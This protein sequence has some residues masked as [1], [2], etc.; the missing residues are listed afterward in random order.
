MQSSGLYS[1]S[2]I[3]KFICKLTFLFFIAFAGSNH[4]LAELKVPG[5]VGKIYSKMIA[6][7]K[8]KAKINGQNLK[9]V[10]YNVGLLKLWKF[11]I[12][13]PDFE[14]RSK[15]LGGFF[16]NYLK[17]ENP[18][19]VL[20]QELW[21]KPDFQTILAL[22]KEH[23]YLPALSDAPGIDTHSAHGLQILVKKDLVKDQKLSAQYQK[24]SSQGFREWITSIERG[25]IHLEFRGLSGKE[26]HIFNTHLSPYPTFN[27]KASMNEILQS[28]RV[29]QSIELGRAVSESMVLS[30]YVISGGDFNSGPEVGGL[31]SK[32]NKDEWY[33]DYHPYE[34]FLITANSN[35][36]EKKHLLDSYRVI[37]PNIPG[38]TQ[39]QKN[40]LAR[41]SPNSGGEPDQRLDY[42]FIGGKSAVNILKSKL[43]FNDNPKS[44]HYGIQTEISVEM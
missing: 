41:R 9:I 21:H 39:D 44:D 18:E 17:D 26:Y 27:P 35:K 30:D 31:T 14:E 10:T 6:E 16:G 29:Q 40:P 36:D 12:I 13:E 5:A 19:I 42:I 7:H 2:N 37:N 43:Q 20:L 34:Q 28:N 24:F 8:N 3:L 15:N 25:F 32:H 33:I 1:I 38:Y 11:R 23:G 22:A 4:L